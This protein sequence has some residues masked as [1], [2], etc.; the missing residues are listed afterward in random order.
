LYSS[1]FNMYTSLIETLH[2][3]FVIV[4]LPSIFADDAIIC[5][6][7]YG[8]IL[9]FWKWT[10]VHPI[11][12]T[13]T[14]CSHTFVLPFRW[15]YYVSSTFMWNMH[16]QIWTFI[17]PSTWFI[18]FLAFHVKDA[19]LK[20]NILYFL[21]LLHILPASIVL[22][23]HILLHILPVPIVLYYLLYNFIIFLALDVKVASS[24]NEYLY[25]S[26]SPC[27]LPR[28]TG[29]TSLILRMILSFLQPFAGTLHF[30]KLNICTSRRHY[31]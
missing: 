27:I 31:V 4:V 19:L 18:I 5:L 6:T 13:C 8:R 17:L 22:Y 15:F 10:Y 12:N 9:Y 29:R 23:F 20:L 21:I 14:S 3:L 11:V 16:F 24:E 30:P 1:K 7:N 26:S 25:F 2:F 28:V